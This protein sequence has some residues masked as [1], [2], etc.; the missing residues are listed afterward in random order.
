MEK[1]RV[2][3]LCGGY[4]AGGP[5]Y[6]EFDLPT[7]AEIAERVEA[8]FKTVHRDERRA[9]ETVTDIVLWALRRMVGAGEE[10]ASDE[11]F[12]EPRWLLEWRRDI[13]ERIMQLEHPPKPTPPATLTIGGGEWPLDTFVDLDPWTP[14]RTRVRLS[15]IVA[16]V[17]AAQAAKARREE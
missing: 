1:V 6:I 15:D 5:Y 11:P 17:E 14:D 16:A 4:D 12:K 2:P 8:Y 9:A 10:K 7:A 13:A 3:V